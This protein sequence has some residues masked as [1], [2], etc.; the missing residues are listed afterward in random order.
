[1]YADEQNN[2]PLY[3]IFERFLNWR[4]LYETTPHPKTYRNSKNSKGLSKGLSFCRW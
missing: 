4:F 2:Q 3:F 1:M